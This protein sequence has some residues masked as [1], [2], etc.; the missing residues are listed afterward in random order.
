A[1]AEVPADLGLVVRAALCIASV[2][3]ISANVP[4]ELLVAYVQRGVINW[5]LALVMARA[6]PDLEERAACLAEIGSLLPPD[7]QVGVFKEALAAVQAISDEWSRAYKLSAVAEHLPP[8]ATELMAEALH[9]VWSISD[10]YQRARTLSVVVRRLPP[11]AT[12]LLAE[13]LR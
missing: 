3:S 1:V 6:K 2:A 5:R 13:A 10:G 7:E 12:E 4:S 11:D 8:D 9:A